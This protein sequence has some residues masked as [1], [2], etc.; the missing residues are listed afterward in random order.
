ME[1]ELKTLLK[2][3]GLDDN[4]IKVY[5]YLVCNKELTAYSIAKENKIHRST[6]YD[7]LERLI[8]K[9]FVNK[10]DKKNKSYYSSNDISRVISQIK[11][12]ETILL[13]IIPKIQNL[14]QN[15]EVKVRILED[16]EGQ[17]QF[18][19]NLFSLA[20]NQKISFC[21]MIGNTYASTLSSNIFIER[22]IKELNGSKFNEKIEY[23]GIWEE[24]YRGDKIIVQYNQL[25]ENRFL[26]ILPSKIGTIICDDFIAF[27]YTTDKP[28]V[29]EVKNKLIA[30][31]MKS[32]FENLWTSSKK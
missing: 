11:D 30:E 27:L 7:I 15:K 32:Y 19:Y 20:K 4:E 25:G 1:T 22:L 8:A 28:Y 21:Y 3:Y 31:E 2:E 23:K 18:N 10:V 24:K 16:A 26:K 29:V 5:L 14:E 12:K 13:S 6:C 9:G 17:K